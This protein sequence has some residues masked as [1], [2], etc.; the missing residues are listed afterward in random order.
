MGDDEGD[1]VEGGEARS[2]SGVELELA[3]ATVP[4]EAIAM[5]CDAVAR[6]GE[7]D[8]HHVPAVFVEQ[9]VLQTWGRELR[10]AES[11]AHASLEW[12][13]GR[14]SGAGVEEVENASSAGGELPRRRAD[15][16]IELLLEEG[17]SMLSRVQRD[18]E[19]LVVE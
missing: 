12:R 6:P 13:F 10:R 9:G 3:T 1:P 17:P 11:A 19:G 14:E 15:E 5:E 8:A 16:F 2:L 4:G 18:L 7:V